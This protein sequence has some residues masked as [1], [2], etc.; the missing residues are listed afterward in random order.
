MHMKVE[1]SPDCGAKK[2]KNKTPAIEIQPV[3]HQQQNN[4]S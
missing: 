4:T 1:D 2:R 3:I